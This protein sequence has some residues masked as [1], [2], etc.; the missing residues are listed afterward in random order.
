MWAKS[1]ELLFHD[2]VHSISDA[3]ANSYG[4]KSAFKAAEILGF[5]APGERGE[6]PA[7]CFK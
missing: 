6:I 3:A 4:G 7:L 1:H 2:C 5:A